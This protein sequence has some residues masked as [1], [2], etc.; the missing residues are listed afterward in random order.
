MKRIYFNICFILM[1]SVASLS[2]CE[3]NDFLKDLG[4]VGSDKVPFVTTSGIS[5]LY[6]ADDTIL[7][8]VYYWESDDN[9]AKLALG[10]GEQTDVA[11][12]ISLDDGGGPVS[13]DIAFMVEKEIGLEGAEITHD[14]LDYE[15][16]RNAYNKSMSYHIGPEYQLLELEDPA[17]LKSLE[18]LAHAQQ[19]KLTILD[20][21]QQNG[22]LVSTWEEVEDI[23]TDIELKIESTLYFQMM[24][25]DA[26][27]E[28]NQSG[29]TAVKVGAIE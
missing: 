9:I 28:F 20:T 15:T 23:T 2:S 6:A 24:V 26:K 17:N 27:E 5:N 22:I 4:E 13:V 19:I 7:F 16:A 18:E 8:N 1:G 21:L 29:V 10:K 3:E 14:P 12:N 11:G 25:I